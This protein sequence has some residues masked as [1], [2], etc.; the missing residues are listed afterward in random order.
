[1]FQCKLLSKRSKHRLYWSTIRQV[2]TYACEARPL[3]DNI[4]QK[5]T[6]FE[7]KI[8]REIY[9]VTK[10]TDGTWRI[11]TNV[12]LDNLI[13]HKNISHFIQAQRLRCLG[14]VERMPEDRDT[15][16]TYKWKL[17]ASRLVGRPKISWMDNVMKDKKAMN[18]VI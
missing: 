4:V 7:W 13:E 12:E 18:I 11:K 17:I 2:V 8:L 6:R 16:K 5:L 10:L 14:P 3:K 9:G 15:K 1:L